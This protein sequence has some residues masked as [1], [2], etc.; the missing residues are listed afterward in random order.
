M[1]QSLYPVFPTP[2]LNEANDQSAH[3]I[4]GGPLFDYEKGDF[5]LDGQ[6]R[7]VMV[8]GR[9]YYTLWVL[10]TLSTQL[11][12]CDSYPDFGVDIEDAMEQPNRQAVQTALEREITEALL[13]NEATER[14]YNFQFEWEASELMVSFIVKPHN[15]DAYDVNMSIVS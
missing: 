9:D 1:A 15:W 4:K 7:V 14:V 8:D 2:D 12:A 3:I 6:N 11:A 5:V 10:K 13:M